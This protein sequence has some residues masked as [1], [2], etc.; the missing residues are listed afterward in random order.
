MAA[1]EI[2]RYLTREPGVRAIDDS[3]SRGSSASW[4]TRRWTG[5]GVDVL[6]FE[7][8]DHGEIIDTKAGRQVLINVAMEYSKADGAVAIKD[9]CN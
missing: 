4:K 1:E 9:T 7:E 8:N 3:R 2:G 6:W 5:K